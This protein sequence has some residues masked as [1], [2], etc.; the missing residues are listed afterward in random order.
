MAPCTNIHIAI[1]Y[2]DKPQA[3]EDALRTRNL[4]G[5]IIRY[6]IAPLW[7]LQN[8]GTLKSWTYHACTD[9]NVYSCLCFF[10]FFATNN[11]SRCSCLVF[12]LQK[13]NNGIIKR[14]SLHYGRVFRFVTGFP[15]NRSLSLSEDVSYSRGTC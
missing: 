14:I 11:K 2:Q 13:K 6:A 8:V 9:Y 10:I 7:L 12:Y 4:P 5:S 15:I 1:Y 3:F